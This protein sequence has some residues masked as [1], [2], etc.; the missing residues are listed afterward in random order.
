MFLR[1][2]TK[3]NRDRFILRLLKF[4]GICSFIAAAVLIALVFVMRLDGFKTRYD[5]Y[6]VMLAQLEQR[7]ASLKNRWLTVL[8]ILLLY[9][10]RS[11]TP[12]YPFPVLYI[13]TAM[14]FSPVNSFIINMAGMAFNI[15]FRYYTGVEMGEG[16][17]NKILHRH[18]NV[19]AMFDVDAR[20]NPFILF[21]MRVVPIMPFSTI[22]HLYG[23]FGYPLVKYMLISLLTIAPRLIPYSFIGNNVYDPLSSGFFVPLSVLFVITGISFFVG[24]FIFKKVAEKPTKESEDNPADAAPPAT[25]RTELNNE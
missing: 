3:E 4:L 11:L 22:S 17:W 19:D 1:H 15:A 23:T 24:H 9:V 25:E 12:I 20:G 8:V 18:P 16:M 7:V 13:M 21:A 5:Q 6:L 2:T 14:V 10:L